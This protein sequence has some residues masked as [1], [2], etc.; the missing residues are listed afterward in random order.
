LFAIAYAYHAARVDGLQTV[1]ADSMLRFLCHH[2]QTRRALH[3]AG[4]HIAAAAAD[5]VL[6]PGWCANSIV[7]AAFRF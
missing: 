5:L 3:T 7:V 1:T 4:D 2:V 6:Q